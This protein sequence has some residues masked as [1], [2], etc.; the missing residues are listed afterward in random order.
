MSVANHF[1][2][3]LPIPFIIS[4]HVQS[5]AGLIHYFQVV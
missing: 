1:I 5:V 2:V 4:L 3:N